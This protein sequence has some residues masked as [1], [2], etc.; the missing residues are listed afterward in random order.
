VFLD[1]VDLHKDSGNLI[2][3]AMPCIMWGGQLEMVSAYRVNGTSSTP[4]AMMVKE[5]RGVNK[6]KASLHRVTIHDAIAQG[7]V[8]KLN[9]VTKKNQ[10][11]EE[12]IERERAKCRT[13]AAWQSQYEC[14]TQDAGGKLITLSLITPCEMDSM[15]IAEILNRNTSALRFGGYDVARHVHA[16]AWHEYALIGVT[17][18]LA[19]REKWH[20]VS[21]DDQEKWIRSRLEDKARPRIS[22]MAIDATGLGMD[23]AERL[24]KRYPGRVDGVNLES[25]RRNELCVMTKD[26]Y[27]NRRVIIPAD[28][29]LRADINAPQK[30]V[31]ANGA[32]RIIIPSFTNTA[33]E[34]SHADEFMA[35]VLAFSA[36]DVG[37][38]NTAS[39]V[40]THGIVESDD[41]PSRFRTH[42][43]VA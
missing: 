8:E 28:D 26:R 38:T 29:Q 5:A 31:A 14:I 37:G 35:Q 15:E 10:T 42:R 33:G 41:T 30:S 12:F 21:F 2:D 18:Y 17:L 43:R 23:M 27:D 11:R 20:D 24:V 25:H 13:L 32:L 19:Y 4:F 3:M 34:R 40:P 7:L 36:A 22:R 1:E 39:E 6:Q 16:S 9:E